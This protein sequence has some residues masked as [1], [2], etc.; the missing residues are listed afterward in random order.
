MSHMVVNKMGPPSRMLIRWVCPNQ[1]MATFQT[2]ETTNGTTRYLNHINKFADQ[3]DGPTTHIVVS[4]PIS[5]FLLSRKHKMG[6][7]NCIPV[8]TMASCNYV[9]VALGTLHWVLCF[10]YS[11]LGTLYWVLR[12][13]PTSSPLYVLNWTRIAPSSRSSVSSAA[14]IS[15]ER[16]IHSHLSPRRLLNSV[17]V[18]KSRRLNQ[19]WRLTPGWDLEPQSRLQRQSYDPPPHISFC[20]THITQRR[21]TF[22]HWVFL[23]DIL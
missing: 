5:L 2:R 16:I 21:E 15:E 11:V 7:A 4:G 13:A 23:P 18:V 8:P 22:I 3:Q 6:C 10:G 12:A 17:L 20:N 14:G 19:G 9:C 1:Q